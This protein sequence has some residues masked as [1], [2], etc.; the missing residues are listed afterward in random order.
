MFTALLSFSAN[1]KASWQPQSFHQHQRKISPHYSLVWQVLIIEYRVIRKATHV[2]FHPTSYEIIVPKY[3]PSSPTSNVCPASP[4]LSRN[5]P[6]NQCQN[7]GN[8]YDYIRQYCSACLCAGATATTHT[9][10]APAVSRHLHSSSLELIEDR[11][12]LLLFQ[13]SHQTKDSAFG[14]TTIP[15]A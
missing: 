11:Q 3:S 12:L 1:V 2:L 14:L 5:D 8:S 15:V 13:F 4:L 6:A 10:T 9:L 7:P